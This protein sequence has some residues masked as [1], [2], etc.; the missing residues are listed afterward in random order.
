MKSR[1]IEK[2]AGSVL[3][4][5]LAAALMC[6]G[7]CKT[8]PENVTN[9]LGMEFI[10]VQPG[11]FLMGC[12]EGDM[13]CQ[14]DERPQHP[15]KISEAFYLG[16]F[17]VTQAQWTKIMG[18]N[19]SRFRGESRPVE[20]VSWDDTQEFIRRLNALEG[21]TKYRLPT[22]AEWEYAA[23]T[24]VATKFPFEAGR[25]GDHVWYWNNADGQTHPVGEK[26]PNP[27]GLHDMH[28]NV[29]EWVQDWYGEG[30]YLASLTTT[31]GA[32]V[33]K[34]KDLLSGPKIVISDPKGPVE[35]TGRVLRGGS[36]GN[37]LRYLR[38]ALRN[39]YAP[40]YRSANVGFRL[41]ISADSGW[42]S[43]VKS[44]REEAEQS[45]ASANDAIKEA[46]EPL[47]VPEIKAPE[48]KAPTLP[49]AGSFG[50]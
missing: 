41:A 22:E 12:S 37:D 16:K 21:T 4:L 7:G 30:Y 2:G 36:W 34:P 33:V 50:K 48:I 49:K 1:M 18:N 44:M 9:T 42:A 11:V 25:A 23:R 20:N 31:P 8:T 27:W 28:G 46:A 38:S 29:W 32:Q 10:L 39:A 13:E 45:A 47:K 3:P 6:A 40:D 5:A 26:Q 43:G 14:G 24:G 17:E 35:G 15:V 19:P